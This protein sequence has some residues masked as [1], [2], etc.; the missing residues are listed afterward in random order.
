MKP[1]TLQCGAGVAL[2]PVNR[3]GNEEGVLGG[4]GAE[5]SN[6]EPELSAVEARRRVPVRGDSRSRR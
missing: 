1:A 6:I 5:F 2:D 4:V 3:R